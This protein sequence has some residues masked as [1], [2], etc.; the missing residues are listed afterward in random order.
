MRRRWPWCAVRASGDAHRW[1]TGGD[2]V[3]G[4][5]FVYNGPRTAALMEEQSNVNQ[6]G[7][8]PGLTL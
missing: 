8:E 2:V 6:T 3:A 4:N 5:R 1:R 7:Y